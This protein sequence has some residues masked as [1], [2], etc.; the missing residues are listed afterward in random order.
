MPLNNLLMQVLALALTT[1]VNGGTQEK[2]SA[3]PWDA[4]LAAL[5]QDHVA[6][7]TPDQGNLCSLLMCVVKF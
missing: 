4:A 7:Q 2:R 6:W 1:V 5:A 3:T